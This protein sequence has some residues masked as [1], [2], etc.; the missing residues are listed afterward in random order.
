MCIISDL[1][2]FSGN[3]SPTS[4]VDLDAKTWSS[5]SRHRTLAD[6]DAVFELLATEP[7]Q[8][9]DWGPNITEEA[10]GVGTTFAGNFER[11]SHLFSI[12]TADDAL[13]ARF[14]A[15]IRGNLDRVW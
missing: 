2:R 14:T 9:D 8:A 10:E 1:Y 15:A 11:V 3:T 6:L 7:L 12:T 13:A 4:G 5:S